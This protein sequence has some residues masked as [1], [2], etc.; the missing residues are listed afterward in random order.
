MRVYKGSV[1]DRL[2]SAVCP[3]R[4]MPAA[5]APLWLPSL[6]CGPL[7]RRRGRGAVGEGCLRSQV[8]KRQGGGRG[9][10]A[11]PSGCQRRLGVVQQ[12]PPRAVRARGRLPRPGQRPPPPPL[13]PPLPP[14]PPPSPPLGR[15]VGK[16]GPAA[17]RRQLAGSAPPAHPPGQRGRKSCYLSA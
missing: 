12:R 5:A 7:S 13:P 17:G 4:V 11:P 1:P 9:G 2:R 10:E 3:G 14:P 16:K 15:A 8:A 6:A